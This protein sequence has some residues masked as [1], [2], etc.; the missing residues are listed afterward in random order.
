MDFLK[1]LFFQKN[2]LQKM[3]PFG[4]IPPPPQAQAQNQPPRQLMPHPEAAKK[5][6][7]G[8]IPSGVP[9]MS[10]PQRME[11]LKRPETQVLIQSKH[12]F[13]EMK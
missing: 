7:L 8:N 5:M 13:I 9:L 6:L 4:P 11:I 10:P 12:F 3:F 1:I 2:K